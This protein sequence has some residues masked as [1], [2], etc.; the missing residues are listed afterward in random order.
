MLR[1]IH[2]LAVALLVAAPAL[3]GDSDEVKALKKSCDAG[4]AADCQVLSGMYTRG[5]FVHLD[6]ANILAFL[7]LAHEK[8]RAMTTT[9]YFFRSRYYLLTDSPR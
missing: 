4:T 6:S 2:A 3:A 5:E 1:S 9:E 7:R 8:H